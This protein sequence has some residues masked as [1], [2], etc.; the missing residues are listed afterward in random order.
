MMKYIRTA[1]LLLLLISVGILL[2]LIGVAGKDTIYKEQ[3]NFYSFTKF[4]AILHELSKCRGYRILSSSPSMKANT[5]GG[6]R[7]V[8]AVQEFIEENRDKSKQETQEK[9]PIEK[10][11]KF[12]FIFI[13]ILITAFF[14]FALVFILQGNHRRK[15]E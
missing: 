5:F 13:I 14:G 2:T 1:P 11:K 3:E 6:N 7:K 15:K 12:I 9:T 8:Q 10:I 4:L